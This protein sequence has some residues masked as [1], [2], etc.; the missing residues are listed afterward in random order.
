[1]HRVVTLTQ[2][3][4][5]FNM[6]MERHEHVL[7]SMSLL[8]SAPFKISFGK[9]EVLQ[10]AQEELAATILKCPIDHLPKTMKAYQFYLDRDA[11]AKRDQAH[12]TLTWD[13]ARYIV[14]YQITG[15]DGRRIWIEER[16]ERIS[17]DGRRPICIQGVITDIQSRR[18]NL[19]NV[20]YTLSLIH[21]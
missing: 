6:T 10:W 5:I 7:T 16:G 12:K 9:V 8:G 15:F 17:G 3:R 4:P 2:N 11:L 1:M 18:N 13:G 20:A 19:N 14:E 21:I